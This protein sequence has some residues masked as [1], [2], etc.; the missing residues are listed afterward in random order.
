[1]TITVEKLKSSTVNQENGA[2]RKYKS[3]LFISL[4]G[5]SYLHKCSN[6]QPNVMC[7]R[8]CDVNCMIRDT[9]VNF[10]F[11]VREISW[12]DWFS[13]RIQL[14]IYLFLCTCVHNV[15]DCLVC[16][17]LFPL[18]YTLYA[19]VYSKAILFSN[20]VANNSLNISQF[21]IAHTRKFFIP[22][23]EFQKQHIIICKINMFFPAFYYTLYLLQLWWYT[24]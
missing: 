19:S 10:L 9:H 3:S 6:M 2:E 18:V 22:N 5:F 24:T 11:Y 4:D 14:L 1:M 16:F 13:A 12:L 17:Q 8:C 7:V 15:C 21:Q 20:S 23:Y